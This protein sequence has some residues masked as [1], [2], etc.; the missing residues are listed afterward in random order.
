M[1]NF[2]LAMALVGVAGDF[3]VAADHLVPQ[4][5]VLV[6]REVDVPAQEAGLLELFEVE[7][8]QNI[9][10]NSLVAQI[11]VRQ[12]EMKKKVTEAEFASAKY[13]AENDVNVE[14]SKASA[15]VSQA[16]WQKAVDARKTVPDAVST[17]ELRRL[18]LSVTKARLGIKQ[19]QME[20]TVAELTAKVKETEMNAAQLDIDRR[21][22]N[23][24]ISGVVMDVYKEKGEWVQAGEPVAVVVQ[25]DVLK[26]EGY[27]NIGEVAPSNV[28]FK[29]VT[30]V[31]KLTGG[32]EVEFQG[33]VTFVSPVVEIGGPYRIS[34]DIANRQDSTG[35]WLLRPGLETTMT[36]HLDA[37]TA[38]RPAKTK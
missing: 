8:G 36:I 34:A 32:E 10:A 21:K 20:Q 19:A 1:R 35:E 38:A 26:V 14:F 22:I 16:E 27:V 7:K 4:C 17:G 25:M 3:A 28:K 24:P 11:D 31:A 12:A 5:Y 15:L 9:E 23:S 13:Q 2:M 6:K 18:E 30:V 29:P 33:K 37:P